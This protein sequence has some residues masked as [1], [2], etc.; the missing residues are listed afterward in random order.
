MVSQRHGDQI[1]SSLGDVFVGEWVN[2]SSEDYLIVYHETRS[3][4][5]CCNNDERDNAG[6][7][8]SYIPW[9]DIRSLKFHFPPMIC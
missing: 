6:E 5:H 8:I 3:V 1:I 9:K 2:M 4:N 7:I